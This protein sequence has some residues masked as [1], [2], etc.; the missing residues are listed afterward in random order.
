MQL[1]TGWDS[2]VSQGISARNLVIGSG[3]NLLD[4]QLDESYRPRSSAFVQGSVDWGILLEKS[5]INLQAGL[6]H[7]KNLS[8]SEFDVSALSG[9]ISK[10]FTLTG[11]ALRTQ[12]ELSEVWLGSRH[13]QRSQAAGVQWLVPQRRGAWLAS[14]N[15]SAVQYLTQP[16]QNAMQLEAG[17]LREQRL[18]AA[19]SVYAG[20][21]LQW[22]NATRSRPGGDRNGYQVQIGAVVAHEQWRF[23][24]Q[25]TYTSWRSKDLFAPGLLDVRRH[26]ELLQLMLQ[27][28]HAITPKT[29]L[30]LEWRGRWARDP[31]PLYRY[32]AQSLSAAL[33][34][35]F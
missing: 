20:L 15:A 8:A 3:E 13:Y 2:N 30:I 18:N 4:L 17:I 6:A 27:A 19:Q 31:I 32:Q 14:L 23:K 5:G 22:D 21:S 11:S 7:R 26:N 24:P 25:A 9:A 1:G 12:L 33:A 16:A 34:H 28:E 35:R 29:S 10:E